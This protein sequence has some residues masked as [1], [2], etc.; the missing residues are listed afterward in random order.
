MF[1]KRL[2]PV[3]S[4]A[5]ILGLL[6]P[7]VS[8]AA[9]EIQKP[10]SRLD[11]GENSAKGSESSPAAND[12]RQAV[13]QGIVRYRSTQTKPKE[14]AAA[15]KQLAALGEEGV[16]VAKDLLDKELQQY[17]T[18]IGLAK[19]PSKLDASIEKF[20]KTL[21]DLRQDA[22]LSKD[23]LHKVGMPALEGLNT[24]YLQRAKT[25]ATQAAKN[26][27]VV[28]SLRQMIAV[29]QLLEEE[30]PHD[31]PLPINDYLQRA[32]TLLSS[33][34]SSPE[35]EQA[36]TILA[37][38]QALASQFSSDVLKG[39]DGLNALRM[40]CGLQPLLYDAKLCKAAQGH[41]KD[42]QARN[43]F[44]HESPVEGKKTSQDRAR[45]VGTTVSGENIYMGSSSPTDALKAWFLSPGHHKNMLSE[46]AR[47]QGLGR[48]GKHWTQMFGAGDEGEKGK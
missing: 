39:M 29:I 20:R 23:E 42:M 9:D 41:S 7:M 2:G 34:Q 43:F 13:R 11:E 15:L 10:A 32:R 48:E 1:A 17:E 12:L 26:G 5:C 36:R 3:G 30:W 44:A 21:A 27:H 25:M 18:A 4:V 6:N 8:L 45:L 47:R 24:V 14:R 16:A 35:E 22:D 33:K 38:N 46:S 19:K 31:A 37:K 28:E 40:T